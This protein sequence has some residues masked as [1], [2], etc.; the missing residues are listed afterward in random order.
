MNLHRRAVLGALLMIVG[1]ATFWTAAAVTAAAWSHPAYSYRHDV[2]SD[3]GDPVRHDFLLDHT[4]NSPL[5]FVMNFGFV[6]EGLLYGVAVVLLCRIFGERGRKTLLLTGE[7]QAF[8]L[9]LISV[10]HEQSLN[11]FEMGIHWVGAFLILVGALTI[12]LVAVLGGQAGAP[13]WYRI[14]SG[15]LAPLVVLSFVA[16]VTVPALALAIGA[17]AMERT[18]MWGVLVWQVIT[19]IMLLVGSATGTL[20]RKESVTRH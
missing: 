17:G 6:L 5:Y 3:L 13:N 7:L 4:I 8:G 10:F 2:I 20:E 16:L 9:V 15:V 19:G 12:F 11:S 18:A 14:L 1:A